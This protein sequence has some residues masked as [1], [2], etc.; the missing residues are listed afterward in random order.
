MD[1]RGKM[2]VQLMMYKVAYRNQTDL[3]L[4]MS[5]VRQGP[6]TR[7][8]SAPIFKVK[9]ANSSRFNKSTA[10]IGPSLWHSL[11]A[12]IKLINDYKSYQNVIRA[13]VWQEFDGLTAV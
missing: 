11:P 7:L 1:L 4:L 2:D 8:A 3:N 10:Y 5:G 6:A 13:Q 12:N 9:K